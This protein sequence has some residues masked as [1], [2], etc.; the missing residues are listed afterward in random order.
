VAGLSYR[1]TQPILAKLRGTSAVLVGGQALNFWAERYLPRVP[2][3]G[4]GA[5]YTSKDIDFCGNR[6]AVLECAQRL[7]GQPI[8]PEVFSPPS[9]G[10]VIF[11]DAAGVQHEI[12]F[13]DRPLT[14]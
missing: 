8:V 6:H 9:T 3:L 7:G 12:D 5:P 14:G 13:I 10:K 2:E 4:R 11:A 1:D